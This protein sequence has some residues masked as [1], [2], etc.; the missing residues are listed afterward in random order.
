M[1][2][3]DTAILHG[4]VK[5]RN[6]A[7]TAA[8]CG[9]L[10]AVYLVLC[11]PVTWERWLLG[12]LLGLV[13]GNGFEYVYHR[14]LLHRPRSPLGA[15]HLTHHAQVGTT[16][17]AEH[18]ALASSPKNVVLLFAV[19]SIPAILI[20]FALGVWGILSGMFIGWAVYLIVAEEIHWRIHMGGWLPGGLRLAR[21]YHMSHHEIP[22][23]RFN[24]FFP[25]FDF[26]FGN[27]TVPRRKEPV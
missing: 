6:N 9:I 12:V 3:R 18:V 20:S 13:W 14:L 25:L 15:G 16:E 8:F 17:E 26:L 23:G 7:I 24:V 5:K 19:N 27:V 22:S 10:P 4:R 21:A 2:A 11:F 1:E